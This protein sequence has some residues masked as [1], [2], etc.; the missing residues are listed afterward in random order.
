M[1]KHMHAH[2]YTKTFIHTETG[3]PRKRITAGV[4]A[5]T[6]SGIH[7]RKPLWMSCPRLDATWGQGKMTD[8]TDRR[9]KQR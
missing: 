3:Q 4:L 8:Q 1:Q 7:R 9:S 5:M 2:N 6:M